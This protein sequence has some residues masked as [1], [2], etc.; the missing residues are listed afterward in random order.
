M[1]KTFN[2]D[3][4][5]IVGFGGSFP[6]NIPDNRAPI[7]KYDDHIFLAKQQSP[8]LVAERI[9]SYER[10]CYDASE[11][12][13]GLLPQPIRCNSKNLPVCILA[14][15]QVSVEIVKPACV[16]WDAEIRNMNFQDFHRTGYL[17]EE[18][19]GLIGVIRILD[20]KPMFFRWIQSLKLWVDQHFNEAKIAFDNPIERACWTLLGLTYDLPE[21]KEQCYTRLAALRLRT[22]PDS[23]P[24][25]F[26]VAQWDHLD[27]DEVTWKSKIKEYL[28]N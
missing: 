6:I 26:L 15:P 18:Q 27:Y 21:E 16:D 7:F 19:H 11:D 2:P 3:E 5:E 20:I 22:A 12:F 8:Q 9:Y 23:L 17:G 1:L 14:I 4:V 10:F 25:L 13:C 28:E 24:N